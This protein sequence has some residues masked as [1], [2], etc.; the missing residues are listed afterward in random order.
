MEAVRDKDDPYCLAAFNAWGSV[1]E[2]RETWTPWA[3]LIQ[4][5][6]HVTGRGLM[7]S[8]IVLYGKPDRGGCCVAVGDPKLAVKTCI[9]GV[10]MYSIAAAW[11]PGLQVG[12]LLSPRKHALDVEKVR[13]DYIGRLVTPYPDV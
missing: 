12:L 6:Y 5:A 11:A 8:G 13:A 4:D 10:E 2:Y 9:A 1:R 3:F 7:L